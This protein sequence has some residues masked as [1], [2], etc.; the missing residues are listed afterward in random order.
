MMTLRRVAP[1][2]QRCTLPI[3][4]SQVAEGAAPPSATSLTV[5]TDTNNTAEVRQ[6]CIVL[7]VPFF[8]AMVGA[9][10]ATATRFL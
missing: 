3:F 10:A 6:Y 4:H 1:P 2:S 9:P 5:Q 8:L 7:A